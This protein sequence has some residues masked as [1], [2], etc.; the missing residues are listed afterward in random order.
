[1]SFRDLVDRIKTNHAGAVVTSTDD[2]VEIKFGGDTVTAK[3]L[4]NGSASITASG[5]TRDGL[6]RR[7]L[8]DEVIEA[9]NVIWRKIE[10]TR[11][12]TS[13]GG[14]GSYARGGGG[15]GDDLVVGES[16]WIEPSDDDD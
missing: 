16:S 9:L 13:S 12:R 3:V 2:T 7:D 4:P 6:M 15:D 5:V 1:M 11:P 8:D 10:A 14:S